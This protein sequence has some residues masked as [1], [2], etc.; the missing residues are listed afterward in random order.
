[1]L[2]AILWIEGET[3]SFWNNYL[4]EQGKYIYIYIYINFV[5]LSCALHG[6]ATSRV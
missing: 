5:K 6:L 4:F 2:W 1:M 3:Y